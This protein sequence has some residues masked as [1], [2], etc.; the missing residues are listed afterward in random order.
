ML[1]LFISL[2]IYSEVFS[3][4]LDKLSS[5][6]ILVMGIANLTIWSVTNFFIGTGKF[7]NGCALIHFL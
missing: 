2:E 5:V 3:D 7:S 1:G 6:T 4:P